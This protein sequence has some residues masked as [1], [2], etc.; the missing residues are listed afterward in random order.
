MNSIKI[1]INVLDDEQWL[2]DMITEIFS[3]DQIYSVH[4]YTDPKSFI[5]AFNKDVD[6][7]ITDAKIHGYD[8]VENLKNFAKIN[9]GCYMVVISAFLDNLYD[10]LINECHVDR[11]VKKTHEITWMHQ[12][13]E[14][15][16]SLKPMILGKA[17]FIQSY[18]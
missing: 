10:V 14:R 8:V 2:L 4:T 15:V 9:P 13:R 3:D 16:E 12:L 7:I 17:K 18:A 6:L 11:T 5:E 1:L